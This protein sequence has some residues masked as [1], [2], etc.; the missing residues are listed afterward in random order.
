[1]EQIFDLVVGVGFG[2]FAAWV[3]LTKIKPARKGKQK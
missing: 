1:M 2:W 3:Y